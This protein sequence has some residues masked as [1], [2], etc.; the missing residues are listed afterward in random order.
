MELWKPSILCSRSYKIYAKNGANSCL[1]LTFS[2][3]ATCKALIGDLQTTVRIWKYISKILENSIFGTN[4]KFYSALFGL[5]NINTAGNCRVRKRPRPHLV[6][7]L[8]WPLEQKPSPS[9]RP[10]KTIL[11]LEGHPKIDRKLIEFA[12]V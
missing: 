8:H 7:D 1:N 6:S 3:I 9:L 5:W 11:G 10:F 4:L 12:S 2:T